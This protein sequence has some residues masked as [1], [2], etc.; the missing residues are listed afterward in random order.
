MFNNTEREMMITDNWLNE[1]VDKMKEKG[2]IGAFTKQ[3]KRRGMTAQQFARYV[4][5][6]KDKFNTRTIRRAVF[7]HN[8]NNFNR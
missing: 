4:L 8:M 1:A 3:A 5:A 2:T 7:A 6:N